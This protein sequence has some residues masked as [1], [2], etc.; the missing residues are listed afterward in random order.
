MYG[1]KSH[2]VSAGLLSVD[3]TSR[4]FFVW[5]RTALTVVGTGWGVYF[6][7]DR[8]RFFLM[9]PRDCQCAVDEDARRDVEEEKEREQTLL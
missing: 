6:D 9:L 3:G 7:S 4:R 1:L 5:V 8:L 2:L